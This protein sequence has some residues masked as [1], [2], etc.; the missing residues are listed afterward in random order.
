MR[1]PH[2]DPGEAAPSLTRLEQTADTLAFHPNEFVDLQGKHYHDP[3]LWTAFIACSNGHRFTLRQ[4]VPCPIAACDWNKD[5]AT[6][7]EVIS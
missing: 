6:A 1:C 5:P 7:P 4:K 2:C 3:R